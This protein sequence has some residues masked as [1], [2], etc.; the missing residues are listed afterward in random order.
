[1]SCLELI[2]KFVSV[3]GI[4]RLL[5]SVYL[6]PKVIPLSGT[7]CTSKPFR[8]L[9]KSY[10]HQISFVQVK[11]LTNKDDSRSSHSPPIAPSP[12]A[13]PKSVKNSVK[14]SPFVPPVGQVKMVRLC[15]FCLDRFAE[16][17]LGQSSSFFPPVGEVKTVKLCQVRLVEVRLGQLRLDQVSLLPSSRQSVW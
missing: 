8:L 10:Y 4:I 12:P 16:V 5:G 17:S 15:Q 14:S 6:G 7:H 13:Q 3:N 2:S 9:L 1:M 11:G